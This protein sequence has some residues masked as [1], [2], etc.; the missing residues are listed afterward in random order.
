M[1]EQA[2]PRIGN[3]TKFFVPGLAIGLFIGGVGGAYLAPKLDQAPTIEVK[4]KTA[5]SMRPPAA[6]ERPL[7]DAAQSEATKAPAPATGATGPTAATGP[8]TEPK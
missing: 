4:P 7:E 2:K 8:A 6:K 1:A 5:G 3:M